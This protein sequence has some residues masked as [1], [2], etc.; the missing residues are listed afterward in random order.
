[1]MR[2]TFDREQIAAFVLKH[3]PSVDPHAT[4]LGIIDPAK[5]EIIAAAVFHNYRGHDIQIGFC[6]DSPRWAQRGV[7]RAVFHYPFVQLGCL[8]LTSIP[9][10]TNIRARKL[11][12][13]LGFKIEGYHPNAYAP[14][15][16]AITY[17][18]QKDECR[19]I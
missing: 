3:L 16:A 15:V 19:W 6:A 9:A 5:N 18:M 10:E 12:E 4:G 8:R 14:G 1:M 17:G 13:G 7:I 11:N 2:L